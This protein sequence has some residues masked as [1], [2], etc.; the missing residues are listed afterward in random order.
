MWSY[1]LPTTGRKAFD[2]FMLALGG[3]AGWILHP[4]IWI[5]FGP[6][7]WIA[8]L[9]A[10]A[11]QESGWNREAAGDGG[12]SVGMLQFYDATWDGLT[13]RPAD[14]RL[15]PFLSGLYAAAYVA[16]ALYTDRRWLRLG[17][18]W[19]GFAWGRWLWTHGYAQSS[20]DATFAEVLAASRAES[21]A[22]PAWY[23]WRGL[24]LAPMLL[25]LPA[26][27]AVPFV[28]KWRRR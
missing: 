15:S 8:F 25:L 4:S 3:L 16:T 17:L 26:L 18:P 1:I 28:A 2:A 24:L 6:F 13:G 12:R 21:R 7:R 27:I 19:A 20:T 23:V 11:A 14:D 22:W 5:V 10:T 9:Q